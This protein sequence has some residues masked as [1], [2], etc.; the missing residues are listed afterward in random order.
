[1]K[2]WILILVAALVST[3]SAE[4]QWWQGQKTVEGNGNMTSVNRSTAD[5]D[6]IDLVGS[7]DIQLVSGIEGKLK[8]EAEENLIDYI[9]T[10]SE[11]GRLRVAVKK[12]YNLEPSGNNG[13]KIIVPFRDLSEVSLTGSGDIYSSEVIIS[14]N[15]ETTVTGSGDIQLPVRAKN[16][17]ASITGS[18][19]IELKGTAN[20]FNCKVTGSG[21]I[22]AFDFQCE[23][24]EALVIGSG[25]IHVYA[26]EELRAKVPGSGDIVYKGNPKKED[27]KTIGVGSISKQ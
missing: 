14:D 3:F 8:I 6:E 2:K 5:Y 27:F 4:A 19:D 21:D 13:I 12:G 20:D 24:V 15:F 7:M 16:A 25:D 9:V 18:G 23:R 1:M 22:M 17:R 11:G 10:E 26:S